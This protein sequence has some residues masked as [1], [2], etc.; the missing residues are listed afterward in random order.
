MNTEWDPEAVVDVLASE[1]SRQ[2]LMLAR[3]EPV[4]AREI[5][6]Q[7]EAS[8]PTVYRQLDLLVEQDLLAEEMQIDPGG[9]HYNTFET[10][11][12]HV[13]FEIDAGRFDVEISFGRDVIDK[14]GELWSDLERAEG[15][16]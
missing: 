15:A 12:D 16:E 4:S 6:R 7:C 1:T 11:L 9:D 5:A 10:D 14:F 2:I 13:C 8:L 3:D